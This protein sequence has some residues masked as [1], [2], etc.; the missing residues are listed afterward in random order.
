MFLLTALE[1]FGQQVSFPTGDQTVEGGTNV[2]IAINFSSSNNFTGDIY[3]TIPLTFNFSVPVT[4]GRDGNLT[5]GTVTQDV[6]TNGR[7]RIRIP[8]S[9]TGTGSGTMTVNTVAVPPGDLCSDVPHTFELELK[10]ANDVPV[11]GQSHTK[12]YTVNKRIPSLLVISSGFAQGSCRDPFSHTFLVLNSNTQGPIHFT[13]TYNSNNFDIVG[14]FLVNGNNLIPLP[15]TIVSTGTIKVV[16][17]SSRY[18]IYLKP[19]ICTNINI[20]PF[21]INEVLEESIPSCPK[22][23]SLT[24]NNTGITEA[25]CAEGIGNPH[26]YIENDHTPL[27]IDG[28]NPMRLTVRINNF[29]ATNY[30]NLVYNLD[31]PSNITITGISPALPAGFTASSLPANDYQLNLSLAAGEIFSF[32]VQ[33]VVN[34]GN[35]LSTDIVQTLKNLSPAGDLDDKPYHIT[36]SEACFPRI[37]FKE[38]AKSGTTSFIAGPSAYTLVNNDPKNIEIQIL[39]KRWNTFE[40]D[41]L[42]FAYDLILNDYLKINPVAPTYYYGYDNPPSGAAYSL[43]IPGVTG[44]YEIS[45]DKK[46]IIFK[47]INME[48]SCSPKNLII[49]FSVTSLSQ[50]ETGTKLG[51]ISKLNTN[52]QVLINNIDMVRWT[53]SS[54]PFLV[55]YVVPSCDSSNFEKTNQTFVATKTDPFYYHYVYDNVGYTAVGGAVMVGSLPHFNDKE[56]SD[57]TKGRGSS[58]TITC[59]SDIIVKS[60][61]NINSV[62]TTTTLVPNTDYELSFSN[63][64]NDICA[65]QLL[66]HTL[67]CTPT[68]VCNSPVFFR[69]KLKTANGFPAFTKTVLSMKVAIPPNALLGEEAVGSFVGTYPANNLMEESEGGIIKVATTSSCIDIPPCECANSFAPIPGKNYV[70]SAWVKEGNNPGAL[71]YENAKITLVFKG[72]APDQSVEAIPTGEIIDGWQRIE[73]EFTVPLS[74][75]KIAIQLKNLGSGDVYFDDVR[76][77]PFDANMK[78]FVYDPVTLRLA[79]ELDERNYATFYEYNEEGALVRVKKETAKGVM[80]IKESRNATRKK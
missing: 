10:D 23:Y 51:I 79:A 57:Q 27:C 15:Y 29:T 16:H 53:V 30:N 34:S 48:Q 14:V 26:P 31:F 32:D 42:E 72:I 64:F 11:A 74:T 1:F 59:P 36:Y 73:K 5:L 63:N 21:T 56:I 75:A 13:Y 50:L 71:K 37:G 9:F 35:P 43:N 77:H 17:Q 4:I 61:K 22:S 20:Q 38:Y 54:N 25:C 46:K 28:C 41:E 24:V 45:P 68:S 3:L 18:K 67:A 78:S 8:F 58:F 6:V 60:Q 69:L 33:Y 55:A 65:G 39:V 76:V 2:P 62:I 44:G 12:I 70:L 7:K 52:Q 66:D 40:V 80:T 49:K 47:N 19:K